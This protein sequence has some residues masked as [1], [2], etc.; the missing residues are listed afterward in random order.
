[1]VGLGIASLAIPMVGAI[2]DNTGGFYWF[3]VVFGALS[4]AT[5]A[6]AMFLPGETATAAEPAAVPGAAE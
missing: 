6:V 2:Y 5:V 4:A 1:M 3:Y